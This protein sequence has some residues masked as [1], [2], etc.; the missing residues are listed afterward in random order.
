M[1]SFEQMPNRNRFLLY[2]NYGIS[3]TAAI[4]L[5]HLLSSLVNQFFYKA[6]SDSEKMKELNLLLKRNLIRK[7]SKIFYYSSKGRIEEDD[8]MNLI[9]Q[10]CTEVATVK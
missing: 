1:I 9:K 4:V 3:K 6:N 5:Y 7:I 8:F 2:G 10:Q